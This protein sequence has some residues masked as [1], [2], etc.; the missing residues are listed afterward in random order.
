MAINTVKDLKRYYNFIETD[1]ENIYK[2]E[3]SNFTRTSTFFEE[4][5]KRFP[6]NIKINSAVSNYGNVANIAAYATAQIAAT[7]IGDIV[8]K[9]LEELGYSDVKYVKVTSRLK[10]TNLIFSGVKDGT[11]DRLVVNA[12]ISIYSATIDMFTK[13]EKDKKSAKTT[14]AASSG[15]FGIA[16]TLR[17]KYFNL[18]SVSNAEFLHINEN[19][20]A[21]PIQDLTIDLNPFRTFTIPNPKVSEQFEIE[22]TDLYRKYG[23]QGGFFYNTNKIIE[24]K[25]DYIT[26]TFKVVLKKDRMAQAGL[27]SY[28][29]DF[30]A[31]K[32]IKHNILPTMFSDF[33]LKE[34]DFTVL[35]IESSATFTLQAYAVFYK[36]DRYPL[37]IAELKGTG[38]THK[39]ILTNTEGIIADDIR[40]KSISS[41]LSGK[42]KKYVVVTGLAKNSAP[43]FK[44]DIE[45]YL[46]TGRVTKELPGIIT[47]Q[48]SRIFP[49][50]KE[51][52]EEL[53]KAY[54]NQ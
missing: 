46:K 26:N 6:T 47:T 42:H 38:S 29:L 41:A 10:G 43:K 28:A 12:A 37:F 23:A 11:L 31:G 39:C 5:T 40:V 7:L 30:A 14:A 35:R 33:N 27:F 25:K 13:Y 48:A 44:K 19:L 15:N 22:L 3:R 8:S 32:A 36:D 18:I 53:F 2:L 21:V 45:S 51:E 17:D 54:R 1:K 50:T 20:E 52:L 9:R 49:G 4:I 16:I 24:E 34:S